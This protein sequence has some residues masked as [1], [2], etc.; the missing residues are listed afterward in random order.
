MEQQGGVCGRGFEGTD[1]LTT[2][3]DLVGLMEEDM[4]LVLK[5][6]LL[7]G[8]CHPPH[9]QKKHESCC[10]LLTFSQGYICLGWSGTTTHT[11]SNHFAVSLIAELEAPLSGKCRSGRLL[12]HTANRFL[13]DSVGVSGCDFWAEQWRSLTDSFE[14]ES[15]F[16][17]TWAHTCGWGLTDTGA[18]EK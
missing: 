9:L 13:N 15:P 4:F 11:F 17:L 18:G 1:T 7:S 5:D 16:C 3:G 12:C 14:C 10:I 6:S 8:S 2:R